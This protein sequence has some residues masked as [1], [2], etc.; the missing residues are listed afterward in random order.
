MNNDTPVIFRRWPD[1]SIIALFPSIPTSYTGRFCQS[2]ERLGGRSVA[3]YLDVISRTTPASPKE[4]DALRR[5]LESEPYNYQLKVYQR[6]TSEH[7]DAYLA[8][9]P[10]RNQTK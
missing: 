1:G 6:R 4:Y 10:Q 7:L 8:R 5:E 2:Y 9:L 3:S